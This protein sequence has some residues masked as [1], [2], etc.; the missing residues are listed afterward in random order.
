M[1]IVDGRAFNDT[2]RAGA[3]FAAIINETSRASNL[4]RAV[5]A[6]PNAAAGPG[7]QR[8]PGHCKSSA[9]R[10][11]RSIAT[12]AHRT[13]R[14]ST[15]LLPQQPTS[16]LE[17]YVRHEP[18]RDVAREIRAAVTE[19]EPTVPVIMLQSFDDAAAIGLLPQ[20]LSAW[21]AGSVGSIG[22]FLAAL[23]LYG[24]MAFLVT[25]RTREIAIRMALG[26]TTQQVRS[27]VLGQAA[28]LGVVGRVHRTVARSRYRHAGAKPVGRCAADRPGLLRHNGARAPGGARG[29]GVD[30]GRARRRHRSR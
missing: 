14:S 27:M 3:P 18:G 22:L 15:F 13:R 28:R 11:M 7:R 17:L 24:L 23:G 21:I 9:S 19:V 1:A 20:K 29:C 25:Q 30:A 8:V 12:S 10:E 2:D 26:A 4:A 6:R 5:C 16:E